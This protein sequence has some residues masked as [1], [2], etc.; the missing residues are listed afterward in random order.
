M[1]HIVLPRSQQHR[2]PG[3]FDDETCWR[4]PVEVVREERDF[5]ADLI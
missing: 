2:L 1:Q 5:Q 3:Y 4:A